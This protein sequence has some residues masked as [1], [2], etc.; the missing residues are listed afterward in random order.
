MTLPLTWVAA[1]FRASA[2]QLN[3][4]SSQKKRMAYPWHHSLDP[5]PH[6]PNEVSIFCKVE[7]PVFI[8]YQISYT[9]WNLSLAIAASALLVRQVFLISTLRNMKYW[10]QIHVSTQMFALHFH[11]HFYGF[12]FET[13]LIIQLVPHF[14]YEMTMG[15]IQ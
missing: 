9:T 15:S 3:H 8:G 5:L 11:T 14:T 10:K 12:C 7:H 13:F 4:L 6:F 2:G 1:S